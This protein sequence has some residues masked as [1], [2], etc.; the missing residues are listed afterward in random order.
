MIKIL[1][2]YLQK[3]DFAFFIDIFF[4]N[5]NFEFRDQDCLLKIQN[6]IKLKSFNV[7]SRSKFLG[8]LHSVLQN[9]T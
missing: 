3:V 4:M 8:Q 5:V 2:I 1:I 7:C 9:L 6:S